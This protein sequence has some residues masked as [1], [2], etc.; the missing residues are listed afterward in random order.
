ML[1]DGPFHEGELRVQM[2]TGEEAMARRVGGMIS[3]HLEPGARRFLEQQTLAAL[4]STDAAGRVWAS[5]LEGEPG[6]V[7]APEPDLVTLDLRT[8]RQSALDP[9][10]QNAAEGSDLGLLVIDPATRRRYRVNGRVRVHG[11]QALQLEVREAFGNCPKYIQKRVYRTTGPMPGAS[12]ETG[13]ELL[14]DE[15]LALIAAAD[16]F[17]IASRHAERGAD[18]SHRG[19]APGFV[20]ALDG[21]TLRVP[22][23][24]GNALFNTLGNLLVDG[25]AGL[26]FPD[27]GS[28]HV[29]QLT[30][31][32]VLRLQ[33]S[34]PAGASGGTGRFWDF[35]VERFLDHALPGARHYDLIEASP[36]NP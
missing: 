21:A 29:L 9:L 1:K 18:V 14:G 30:G 19:G 17:F 33:Q 28:G 24:P 15:Q 31:R 2:A 5:V 6:F 35:S 22:D 10:W 23:Y 26:V 3:G 36:Y 8:V 27:F 4:A 13:G 12:G 11:E 25:R 32:V 34:D 16:T 7:R 20:A